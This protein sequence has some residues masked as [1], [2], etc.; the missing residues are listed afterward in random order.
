MHAKG[1]AGLTLLIFSFLMMPFGFNNYAIFI[2][3]LATGLS[4]IPDIDLEYEI[5]H[6]GFT[7]NILFALIVGIVTG[8]LFYMGNSNPLYFLIGFLG[9]FGGIGSHIIGDVLTHMKFKPLWPFSKKEVALKLCY[10]GDKK[11]NDGLMTA[12]ITA[13]ILYFLITTGTLKDIITGFV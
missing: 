1:H 10:A 13:F 2:I 6:R 4:S 9:G 11:V 8:T 5:K 12:G 3:I 7:H